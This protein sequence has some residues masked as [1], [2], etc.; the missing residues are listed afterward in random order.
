MLIGHFLNAITL[1]LGVVAVISAVFQDWGEFGVVV[2]VII[3]NGLLGFYQ[4]YGAEKSLQGL[5]DMTAGSAKVKRS[6]RISVIPID[7]VVVGD[8]II[9]EQGTSV[10]ADLRL[11]EVSNLEIDEALL[12][13]EALPVVKHIRPIPDPT[14]DCALGDRK[15]MA[16]RNT[17]VTQGRGKGIVVAGG[18]K[19]EM[20]KLADRLSSDDG[21]SNKT[22][23]QKKMEYL[24]YALF[25]VCF[26]LAIIVFAANDFEYHESTLLYAAAVA[27]AILPESLVAV[28]TVAMTISVRRMASQRCIVRKLGALEG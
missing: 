16:F 15:N 25:G 8:V 17:L 19:T 9:L 23:L 13:G 4:E 21:G 6:G 27:I 10:P 12:T 1:I 22:E 7:E 18:L 20:G 3:F 11:Y 26:I 5:K 28:M 24:M 2:F 14:G